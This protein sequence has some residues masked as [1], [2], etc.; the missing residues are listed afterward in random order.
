MPKIKSH[1]AAGKR[2]KKTATGKFKRGSA[3]RSHILTKKATKRKREL[4][5]SAYVFA[6]D[7]RRIA[8][9]LPYA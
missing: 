2:F 6:G 8:R 3:N 4:R 1:R 5:Q 7:A 9:Q